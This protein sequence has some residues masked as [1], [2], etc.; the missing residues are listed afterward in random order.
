MNRNRKWK[1]DILG[2]RMEDD[3]R[4]PSAIIGTILVMVLIMVAVTIGLSQGWF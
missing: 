4:S 2:E 3:Y 1:R